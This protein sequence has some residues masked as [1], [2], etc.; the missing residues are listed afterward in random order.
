MGAQPKSWCQQDGHADYELFEEFNEWIDEGDIDLDLSLLNELGLGKQKLS[1][2]SKAFFTGDRSAYDQAL[3]TFQGKRRAEVLSRDALIQQ[4]GD[5]D[6]QHWFERNDRRFN[7]LLK[8]L[9]D[10]A[11]VPFIG[12]GISEGGGFP[13]WTQHLREQ[14]RT[15]GIAEARVE[16][17]LA[18]GKYEEVIAHIEQKRGIRVFAQEIRDTFGRSGKLQEVTLRVSELFTDTL[19]T[20]NY[21]SL[22]EDVFETG[23]TTRVQVINGVTSMTLP[24][25]DKTTIIKIHGDFRDPAHCILA[26][27]Q[28]DA[29]YGEPNLN[30][31]LPIPRIL[32]RYFRSNSL[33]FLGCSLRN[34]R[35][36][37]VFKATLDAAGD[38][39][40]PPHFAFTQAP[41][42]IKALQARNQE[43]VD[44][45]LAPIWYPAGQHELV[46][47]I[48][49]HARN[50]LDYRK[51]MTAR[52]AKE[53]TAR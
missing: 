32:A 20:T 38:F 18:Q 29:A 21:D 48:L 46:E 5:V 35:T 33:L 6:G 52:S 24:D 42:T 37:H 45:G 34:D 50:E 40:F 25:P 15:A 9:E 14:G 4:F 7:Q 2:P 44:L 26:K 31:D 3:K 41:D 8:C 47:E 12:A 27:S 43:L 23:E 30:L 51:A 10:N 13:T 53:A 36:L 22:L 16:R 49:R 28:Y 17:W 19:I 1:S 11:V 39:N